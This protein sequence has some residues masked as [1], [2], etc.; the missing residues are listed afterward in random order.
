MIKVYKETPEDMYTDSLKEFVRD[1]WEG[2]SDFPYIV[3]N[4]HLYSNN[5][6]SQGDFEYECPV[7]SL[8]EWRKG[9][10]FR[11]EDMPSQLWELTVYDSEEDF[12]EKIPNYYVDDYSIELT[13]A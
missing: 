2:H 1:C 9:K 3:I 10:S 7:E 8:E 4:G 6:S 13:L 11:S 5:L 12:V